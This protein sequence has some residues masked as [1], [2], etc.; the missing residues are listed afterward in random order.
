MAIKLSRLLSGLLSQLIARLLLIVCF[1]AGLLFAGSGDVQARYVHEPIRTIT[2]FYQVWCLLAPIAGFVLTY[3]I[4][5]ELRARS[6]VH[7]APRVLN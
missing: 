4:C 6:G 3:A 7:A 2:R 1:C 5:L